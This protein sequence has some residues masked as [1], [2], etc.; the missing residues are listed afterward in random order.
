MVLHVSLH[1]S[2]LLT[3]MAQSCHLDICT[4]SKYHRP[5][6]FMRHAQ[7]CLLHRCTLPLS[8]HRP[9]IL[10][11]LY[12]YTLFG[13]TRVLTVDRG[14]S[15]FPY[16]LC[17]YLYYLVSCFYRSLHFISNVLTVATYNN[18]FSYQE[19]SALW[20][21]VGLSVAPGQP[22]MFYSH[23]SSDSRSMLLNFIIAQ[24]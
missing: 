10:A 8:R 5:A 3:Q 12:S 19:L 20:E 16:G 17:L 2:S 6:H 1:G 14:W 15:H 11:P 4:A 9:P 21:F 24:S 7:Y 13:S 23:I 18:L 22:P